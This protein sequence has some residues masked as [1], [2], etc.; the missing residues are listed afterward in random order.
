MTSIVYPFF[1][2]NIQILTALTA[3][4]LGD[5]SDEHGEAWVIVAI[6]I[7]AQENKRSMKYIEAIL[8]RWHREG[9]GT[10]P[11]W[12]RKP[13]PQAPQVGGWAAELAKEREQNVNP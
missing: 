10:V 12:Q 3:E 1:E 9:Y 11:A 7:A 4:A 8:N 5:L 13:T 6:Y 2:S